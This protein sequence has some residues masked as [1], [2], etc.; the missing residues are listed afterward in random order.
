MIKRDIR[1]R[2]ETC[3]DESVRTKTF[4]KPSYDA[5]SR[6]FLSIIPLD[7]NYLLLISIIIWLLVILLS[8][9]ELTFIKNRYK[10]TNFDDKLALLVAALIFTIGLFYFY[11]PKFDK[12]NFCLM[13]RNDPICEDAKTSCFTQKNGAVF[14]DNFEFG[15]FIE[16]ES[17]LGF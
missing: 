15:G 10:V 4:C 5:E 17:G 3:Y 14:A 8:I 2:G 11:Y 7:N 16:I 12:N 9:L 13:N 1:C 6:D